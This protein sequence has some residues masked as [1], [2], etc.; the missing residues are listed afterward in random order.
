MTRVRARGRRGV[1]SDVALLAGSLAL[2][3]GTLAPT[4]YT[5]DSA[6]LAAGAYSLGIVHST[7]YPLY[8]LLV[9]AFMLLVPW[10]DMAYRANLFSALCAAVTLVVLGRAMRLLA[11]SAG[12]ALAAAGLVGVSFPF[13]SQAVAAEVYTLHTLFV[14]GMLW[15]LLAWRAAGRPGHFVLLWL[16]FGLSLGNHISTLLLLP[17]LAFF[18]W[19]EGG[20]RRLSPGVW[21]LAVGAAGLGPLTYLYLPCR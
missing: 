16:T 8:L 6:E 19:R 9:K 17:G 11:G 18:V 4:V 20:G 7:G 13:W 1:T 10:G 5:F 15:L 2:Y 3:L 14:A 12:A 21:T